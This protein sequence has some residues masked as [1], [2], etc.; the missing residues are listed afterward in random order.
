[1]EEKTKHKDIDG[2]YAWVILTC[3]FLTFELGNGFRQVFGILYPEI[4]ERY[5]AGQLQT[6]WIITIQVLHWGLMGKDIFSHIRTL[7][8]IFCCLSTTDV[9]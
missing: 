5:E 4:L 7:L 1:M 3:A 6:S 2:G 9:V 8:S